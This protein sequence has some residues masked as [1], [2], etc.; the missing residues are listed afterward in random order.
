VTDGTVTYN[1]GG[2][3]LFTPAPESAGLTANFQYRIPDNGATLTP[4]NNAYVTVSFNVAVPEIHVVRSTI[5]TSPA[6]LSA[7]SDLC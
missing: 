6:R 7:R 4:L 1:A 3:F 2:S 5:D